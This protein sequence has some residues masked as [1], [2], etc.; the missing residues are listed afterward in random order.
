MTGELSTDA[1]ARAILAARGGVW[2]RLLAAMGLDGGRKAAR[3]RRAA[4]WVAGGVGERQTNALLG[5]LVPY[6]WNGWNDRAL[7]GWHS[8]NLDHVLIPPCG[9]FLV[10]VDTKRW[11]RRFPVTAKAGRLHHGEYDRHKSV[12]TIEGMSS[13]L[14]EQLGKK[15][16]PVRMVIAVHGAPVAGGR[17][18]LGERGGVEVMQ[19][20]RLVPYLRSLTGRPDRARFDALAAAAGPLLR[21]YV[22]GGR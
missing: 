3:Q 22:E 13:T 12:T 16:V 8:A 14:G 21:R 11:D 2:E 9:R 17:F 1:K 18:Q 5:A 20:D 6:G 15:R 19:S 4:Q 10:V 7:T